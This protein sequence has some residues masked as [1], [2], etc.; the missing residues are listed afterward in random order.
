MNNQ[1]IKRIANYLG[2]EGLY[3]EAAQLDKIVKTAQEVISIKGDKY[4]YKDNGDGTYTPYLGSRKISTTVTKQQMLDA[5][6]NDPA[7]TEKINASSSFFSRVYEKGT[8]ALQGA[9]DYVMGTGDDVI[10]SMSFDGNTLTIELHQGS[11][12]VRANSGLKSNNPYNPDK[13]DYTDPKYSNL[14]NKGPIPAG[15]YYFSPDE[16]ERSSGAWGYF[17]V[18][19]N[20]GA[21][22]SQV[23][24]G[25]DPTSTNE[26]SEGLGFRGGFYLHGDGG[27]D[28]TAG[29]IG[30]VS[31]SDAVKVYNL[32]KQAQGTAKYIYVYVS[33]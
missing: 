19:L 12:Q 13:K 31:P 27:Q 23:A 20:G 3:K 18:K 26:I 33:Y 21:I 24:R 7:A 11:M 6:K 2:S 4:T 16:V 14:A 8:E 25:L 1:R 5:A 29:C 15:R 28:G 32:I 22:S 17:R 9:K 30:I 10:R